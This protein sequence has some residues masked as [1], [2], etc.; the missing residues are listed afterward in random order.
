MNTYAELPPSSTT[1]TV[2]PRQTGLLDDPTQSAI[3]FALRELLSVRGEALAIASGTGAEV[4]WLSERMSW[5]NWQPTDADPQQLRLLATYVQSLNRSNL[6]APRLLEVHNPCWPLAGAPYD[7]IYCSNLLHKAAR[8][9]SAQVMRGAAMLLA[10]G[11]ALV[12]RGPFLEDQV[13]TSVEHLALDDELRTFNPDW[14]LRRREDL[15]ICAGRF[16]LEMTQR[17][18][19]PDGELLLVWEHKIRSPKRA[20]NMIWL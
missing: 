17:I 8:S 19:L 15:E 7:L 16:G 20:K 5:V 4:G 18:E 9:S 3:Y 6:Q 13:L 14:G 12:T 11:G 10:S 2:A 1:R